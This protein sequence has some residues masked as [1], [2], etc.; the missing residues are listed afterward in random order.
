M[1]VTFLSLGVE[2]SFHLHVHD[3]GFLRRLVNCLAECTRSWL[4]DYFLVVSLS[5]SFIPCLF[6][7]DSLDRTRERCCVLHI[8]SHQE[9]LLNVITCLGGAARSLYVSHFV[10]NYLL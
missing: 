1:V 10:I 9:V 8:L 4:S 2:Q 5:C 6:C 3:A 7:Q